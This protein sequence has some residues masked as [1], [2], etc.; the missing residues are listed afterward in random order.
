METELLR[1][2]EG[3]CALNTP[4]P[5]LHPELLKWQS[6]FFSCSFSVLKCPYI[7]DVFIAT[8]TFALLTL[9]SSPCNQHF[10]SRTFAKQ[11]CSKNVE[12]SSTVHTSRILIFLGKKNLGWSDGLVTKCSSCFPGEPWINS[13]P[14]WQL[15]PPVPGNPTLSHRHSCRQNTNAHE[16]KIN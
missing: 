16:I 6:Q 2:S 7:H 10:Y 5:S 11:K 13:S 15:I 12:D 4:E 1:A 8:Q 9:N 3:V 14:I